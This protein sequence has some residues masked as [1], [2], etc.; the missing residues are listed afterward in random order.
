M[1]HFEKNSPRQRISAST[2]FL[3]P[4]QTLE[5]FVWGW[6]EG[7]S[8][9][10]TDDS[11]VKVST[12]LGPNGRCAVTGVA[13]NK[14]DIPRIELVMKGVSVWDY[15][16][17]SVITGSLPPG[18][19]QQQDY[20][21]PGNLKVKVTA[22]W[23]KNASPNTFSHTGEVSRLILG[24]HGLALHFN[25]GLL[26]TEHH[27]LP[28]DE[29]V[30]FGGQIE[31][32][33]EQ[34]DKTGLASD[35]NLVVIVAPCSETLDGAGDDSKTPYGWTFPSSGKFRRPFVVINSAKTSPTAV[36]LVHEIGHAAGLGHEHGGPGAVVGNFM[37]EPKYQQYKTPGTGMYRSQVVTIANAFFTGP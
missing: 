29:I 20:V 35:S 30:Q 4:K 16:E 24:R 7:L 33:R 22:F 26:P 10:S 23:S 25:P 9:R 19:A 12:Q 8:V 21:H 6:V 2:V 11:V 17:A 28:F 37:N 32:L 5:L 15:F 18:F 36:T 13:V 34:V 3:Q 14:S 27:R 31:T 1:A